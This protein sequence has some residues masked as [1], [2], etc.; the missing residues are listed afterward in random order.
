M[1]MVIGTMTSGCDDVYTE[2]E[3]A[4]CRNDPSLPPSDF[5][6]LF[7]F[8]IRPFPAAT[9]TRTTHRKEV[10]RIVESEDL[11]AIQFNGMLHDMPPEQRMATCKFLVC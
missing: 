3:K 2:K 9:M 5:K 8:S 6:G 11:V 1:A 7:L 10:E 4:E